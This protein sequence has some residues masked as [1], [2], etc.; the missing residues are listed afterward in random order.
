M[1]DFGYNMF[2]GLRVD[3]IIYFPPFF[4]YS[5]NIPVFSHFSSQLSSPYLRKDRETERE[6]E[7]PESNLPI[8][9]PPC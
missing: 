9:F 2:F 7:I 1:Y 6:K 3:S 5:Y 8:L 4:Y